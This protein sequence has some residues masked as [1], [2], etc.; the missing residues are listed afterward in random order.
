MTIDP[1]FTLLLNTTKLY[2]C[3]LCS[4]LLHEEGT[5]NRRK[6]QVTPKFLHCSFDRNIA[7]SQDNVATVE[8]YNDVLSTFFTI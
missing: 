1:Y 3:F 2:N 7:A 5:S 6:F 4:A 8:F